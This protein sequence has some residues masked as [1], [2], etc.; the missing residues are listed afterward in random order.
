MVVHIPQIYGLDP[1][2]SLAA[3]LVFRMLTFAWAFA[4]GIPGMFYA[5][6][7][8]RAANGGPHDLQTAVENDVK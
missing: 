8:S 3:V 7:A 5:L 6:H 4:L 2:R 1:A